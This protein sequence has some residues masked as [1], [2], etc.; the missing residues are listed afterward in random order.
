MGYLKNIVEVSIIIPMYNCEAYII[1]CIESIKSQTF[2]RYEV[3]IVDDG[4]TDSSLFVC[5]NIIGNDSRFKIIHKNNTG[6][7]DAR[8]Y[9]LSIAQ[10]QTITFIDADDWIGKTY[11]QELID[12]K[13][14]T[15]ADIVCSGYRM[16]NGSKEQN[17][18]KMPRKVLST[19]EALDG[20]SPYYFT[21]VWGKLFDKKILEN[22]RFQTDIFYSEDTLFYT[23]AVLN[24]KLIVW[25]DKTNYFYFS[26]SFGTIKNKNP[27]KYVT[28]FIA[29]KKIV[30]LQKEAG[31]D[32]YGV[33][34]WLFD[35][36]VN[37]KMNLY[38]HNIYDDPC[39]DELNMIIKKY[40]NMYRKRYKTQIKAL[41]LEWP[42]L[43]K[44]YCT[45]KMM[46]G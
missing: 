2:S 29:R 22:I 6:V 15:G 17:S 4:S 38:K 31:V 9:G 42:F 39:L 28:E 33:E 1:R 41:T 13:R 27:Q 19:N 34:Y 26:N 14:I 23:S 45:I 21:S 12:E 10:G 8:N 18:F 7:S 43:F 40:K 5:K 36:A 32:T 35:S 16:S 3:I 30:N 37:V 25:I 11:L 20:L 44:L 24:S 46:K